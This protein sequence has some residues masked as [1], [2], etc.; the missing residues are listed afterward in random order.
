M[1]T[2]IQFTS[3]G[4]YASLLILALGIFSRRHGGAP[5][6]LVLT[7]VT[8]ASCSLFA[9]IRCFCAAIVEIAVPLHLLSLTAYSLSVAGLSVVFLDEMVLIRAFSQL[10]AYRIRKVLISGSLLVNVSTILVGGVS[11]GLYTSRTAT[12]TSTTAFVISRFICPT[13]LCVC[14]LVSSG[15]VCMSARHV[16][17]LLAP[18]A[19]AE[20]EDGTKASTS[21]SVEGFSSSMETEAITSPFQKSLIRCYGRLSL[22]MFWVGAMGLVA[23]LYYTNSDRPM[24]LI[25]SA[26]MDV[27]LLFS[28][29][30]V[31]VSTVH[32]VWG[33]DTGNIKH[34]H[35]TAQQED[36]VEDAS[37]SEDDE[38]EDNTFFFPVAIQH[39]RVSGPMSSKR[40]S[41]K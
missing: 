32:C 3:G 13:V 25:F 15:I 29:V 39:V 21:M 16:R 28:M 37:S 33:Q 14:L 5:P 12:E 41:I 20:E 6:A 2:V 17:L 18:T 31:M 10:F 35:E 23:N 24:W 7:I 8:I 38:Q 19:S 30:D 22:E 34:A 4:L 40:V 11:H 9:A 27:G 1:E 26:L 36:E